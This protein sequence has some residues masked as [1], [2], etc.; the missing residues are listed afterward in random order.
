MARHHLAQSKVTDSEG[1][2]QTYGEGYTRKMK[3]TLA[4][5]MAILPVPDAV[6]L[7]YSINGIRQVS[8]QA[9]LW[10]IVPSHWMPGEM[11]NDE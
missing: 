3:I 5:P 11:Q 8:V 7:L 1:Q 9:S 10:C 2:R 4:L 6:L